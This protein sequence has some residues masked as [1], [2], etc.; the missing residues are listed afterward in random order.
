[1]IRDRIKPM[2]MAEFDSSSLTGGYD[3][4]FK[5]TIPLCI[6]KVYNTS[7]VDV[8]IS[9]DGSNDHDF[10]FADAREITYFQQ[11]NIPNNQKSLLPKGTTIYIKG[12]AGQGNIYIAGY[13]VQ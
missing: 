2:V 12:Q 7:D 8:I 11:A 10:C 9:Y 6:L 4:V 3:F 5:T 1:M 13:G